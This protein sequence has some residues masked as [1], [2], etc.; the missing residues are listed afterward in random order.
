[1][2][3][4]KVY[5]TRRNWDAD[6]YNDLN[7]GNGFLITEPADITMDGIKRK[8]IYGARSVL[9]GSTYSDEQ[10]F[11]ERFSCECG[12]YQGRVHEGNV[13][14]ICKTEVVRKD[15][16]INFTG[17][18]SLGD[19]MVVNPLYYNIL[20]DAIGKKIFP[21]ILRPMEKVDRDGHRSKITSEDYDDGKEPSSPFAF[22]GVEEFRLRFHEI[23]DYFIEFRKRK[24][25]PKVK[26]LQKVKRESM[27]VFVSHIPIYSTF[28]RPQSATSD[29]FYYTGIDRVIN[30]LFSLSEQVK[31]CLDIERPLI[32]QK[33][34]KRANDLWDL[35][36][37]LLNDKN[38]HIRD[39]IMGGGL[40]FS[41]RNVICPDITLRDNE[42]DLSY[43]TFW[44]LFKM[45]II[46][47]LR[48]IYNCTLAQAKDIWFRNHHYNEHMARI[49]QTIVN[50]EKL[51]VV[52]NRNPTLNY[53]SILRMR[54]RFIKPDD[55]DYCLSVPMSVL[56]G[57]NADF[58]GD[59]INIVAC[60]T[61]EIKHIFRNYDPVRRMIISRDTGYLNPYFSIVKSERINLYWFCTM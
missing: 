23:M 17:W 32:L 28:L 5:A 30:P 58:D 1:M 19:A 40:N 52:I 60:M 20:H 56:P 39:Q 35:N 22:I 38:G 14:P 15:I 11:I 34:Q 2:A 3:K 47:Y 16:N 21:D 57:L 24:N 43:H 61:D 41:S 18:I 53:Y 51:C 42:V 55:A 4:Q 25:S 59:I 50:V 31:T 46:Y 49:M 26:A 48:I 6:C 8:S 12:N 37:S 13:C 10:S 9:Y 29:S 36:F 54:I 7:S 33:I 44:V 45:K 27:N